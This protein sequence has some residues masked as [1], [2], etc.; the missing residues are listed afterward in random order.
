M[1]GGGVGGGRRRYRCVD[2][3]SWYFHELTRLI[4]VERIREFFLCASNV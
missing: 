3:V 2:T 1:G 4:C